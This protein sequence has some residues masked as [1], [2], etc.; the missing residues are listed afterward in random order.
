MNSRLTSRAVLALPL[1]LLATSGSHGQTK[2]V[3]T[4][5]V[6]W[7]QA[8]ATKADWGELRAHF[9]GDTYGLKDALAATAVLKPGREIHPPHQHAE[10]EVL[11][12]TAGQGRWHLDGK[13]FPAQ[14]GDAIYAAPWVVHGI[15]NT[16]ET[17]LT[18]VVMKWN[19]KGVAVTPEPGKAK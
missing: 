15:T 11:V 12:V 17:P 14:T 1:F 6:S 16:G 7:S 5:H 13:D 4:R 18:F 8:T 2:L 3:T 19:S 9:E 10:E